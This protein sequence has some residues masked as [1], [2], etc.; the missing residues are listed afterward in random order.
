MPVATYEAIVENGKIRLPLDI[1]LPENAKVYVVVPGIE[2]APAA[3][4]VSPSLVYSEEAKDVGLSME[5]DRDAGVNSERSQSTQSPISW[6][7]FP[8]EPWAV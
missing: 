5:E 1:R 4:I 7:G 8:E 6:V 3:L 2:T